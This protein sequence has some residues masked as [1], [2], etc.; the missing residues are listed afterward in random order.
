MQANPFLL[1]VPFWTPW[2][3]PKTGVFW[4]FQRDQKGTLG[5]KGLNLLQGNHASIKIQKYDSSLYWPQIYDD[6]S[7]NGNKP[8]GYMKLLTC[9]QWFNV[10][11]TP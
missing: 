10:E 2:T 5:R 9:F 4:C 1:N 7:I 3:H 6:F 11:G 8:N